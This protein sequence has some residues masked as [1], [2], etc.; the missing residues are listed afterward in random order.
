MYHVITIFVYIAH[1]DRVLYDYTTEHR[2]DSEPGMSPR[3]VYNQ[4]KHS[5]YSFDQ[6]A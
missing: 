6:L 1:I 3:W 2:T 4:R 5:S